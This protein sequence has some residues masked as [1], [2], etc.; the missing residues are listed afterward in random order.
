MLNK[1]LYQIT[2]NK[3][4]VEIGGPSLNG[5]LIYEHAYSIDNIVFSKKTVWCNHNDEYN[6]YKNKKGKVIIND[7]VNISS[8]QNEVYDFVF[9]S[10]SLEHIANPLKAIQ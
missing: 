6:Y 8:L 10:L 7:A 1:F 3:P 5:N 4:G 2:C 9:S